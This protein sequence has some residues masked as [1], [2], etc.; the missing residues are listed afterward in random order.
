VSVLYKI[1]LLT[2]DDVQVRIFVCVYA[3]WQY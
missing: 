2:G 1:V 3:R